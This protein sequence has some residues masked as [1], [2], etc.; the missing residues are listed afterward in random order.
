MGDDCAVSDDRAP[1]EPPEPPKA[2]KLRERASRTDSRPRLVATAKF[3]RHLLP[4]DERFGDALSTTGGG[5]NERIGRLLSEA[6]PERPSAM[7]E[8]GLGALQAWQALS[9]AQGRGRGTVDL[10]IM[11]TD[12]VGFSTWALEAGDEAALDLLRHVAGEEDEAISL[13][14]GSV[15]KRLG[16]GSMS[17]FRDARSAIA[18]ALQAQARVG[19][20]EV[21]GHSPELRVGVHVGRPRRV[22]GDYLGVD[23]NIAARVADSAD[24][25]EVL[26]SAQAREQLD[27]EGDSGFSFARGRRLKASGAPRGLAVYQVTAR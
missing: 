1:G 15:V 18:A 8:L 7:R 11:F 16:D 27:A 23:V 5:A 9:E 4:G 20:V 24:G 12:V 17:V 6:Q 3:I 13:H 22:G 2:G 26:V 10:A 21:R 14:G 25:G 19:E